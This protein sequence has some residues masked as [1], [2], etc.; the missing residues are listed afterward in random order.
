[1]RE[2]EAQRRGR[3]ALPAVSGHC[4]IFYFF[5]KRKQSLGASTETL[6]MWNPP[7]R[8]HSSLLPDFFRPCFYF[9]GCSLLPQKRGKGFFK[10]SVCRETR[11]SFR[12]IPG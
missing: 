3:N 4:F 9:C 11:Y 7:S 1:M 6:W 8:P 10:R 12:A 2:R 5:F